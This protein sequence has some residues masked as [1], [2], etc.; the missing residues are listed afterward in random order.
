MK[1]CTKCKVE[2]DESDFHKNRHTRSGL[3]SW[4]K[5]CILA[6]PIRK[7]PLYS[8]PPVYALNKDV[9]ISFTVFT[10]ASKSAAEAFADALYRHAA[11]LKFARSPRVIDRGCGAWGVDI[12]YGWELVGPKFA[13]ARSEHQRQ[14]WGGA[15]SR[16]P[17]LGS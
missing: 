16:E 11:E 5:R 12:Y 13:D 10:T 9:K 7:R 14:L 4:C 1:M 17:A 2:K 3:Q 8:A 6:P 15:F